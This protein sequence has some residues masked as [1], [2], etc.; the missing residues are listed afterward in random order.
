MQ[1]ATPAAVVLAPPA[2]GVPGRLPHLV[3]DFWRWTLW[4]FA[5]AQ[6]SLLGLPAV[7]FLKVYPWEWPGL[8]EGLCVFSFTRQRPIWPPEWLSQLT[9]QS[10]FSRVIFCSTW[11]LW[12]V[13]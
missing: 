2:W 4:S 13:A 1:R 3:A 10:F 7:T 9:L 11:D 6:R 12:C 8:A 5:A